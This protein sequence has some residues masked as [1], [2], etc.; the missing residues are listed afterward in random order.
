MRVRR[1][2]LGRRTVVKMAAVARRLSR[3]RRRPR[4][5]RGTGSPRAP[6]VPCASAR[7]T[8]STS[9]PTCA[10]TWPRS[11]FDGHVAVTFAP[12]R[13]GLSVVSLDAAA[14]DDREGRGGRKAALTF[15]AGD[16]TLRV[17]LPASPERR[18]GRDG[19]RHLLG[20]PQ[21]RALL[22]AGRLQAIRP[23]LELRRGGAPLR[24]DSPL[25]R[26]QRPVHRRH[27][28]DGSEATGRRRGTES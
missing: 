5:R 25:Q 10:S 2:Y 6:R 13:S 11:R 14:L 15:E 20:P 27:D 16:R 24:V 3:Y 18:R 22:P 12:L 23:G 4:C 17:T 1:P 19:G 21:V 7:S 8:S 28:R 26:H 9:P